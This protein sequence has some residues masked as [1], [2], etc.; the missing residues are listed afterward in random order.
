[1][2]IHCESGGDVGTDGTATWRTGENKVVIIVTNTDGTRTVNKEYTAVVTKPPSAKLSMVVGSS[3]YPDVSATFD[4]RLSEWYLDW[5]NGATEGTLIGIPEDSEATV[6]W[7]T[8]SESNG[9]I[10]AQG[11][12]SELAGIGD[13]KFKATVTNGTETEDWI[14][15]IFVS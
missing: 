1:M 13:H 14:V 2:Y 4:A 8:T 9:S 12:F 6:T 7:S 15:N 11:E 5:Q 10:T 3:T